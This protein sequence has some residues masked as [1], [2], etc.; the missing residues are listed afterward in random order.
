MQLSLVG[1]HDIGERVMTLDETTD[2]SGSAYIY[3]MDQLYRLM[4][5]VLI[6]ICL[7]TDS[8]QRIFFR[9]LLDG[10]AATLSQMRWSCLG[11]LRVR[12]VV[13]RAYDLRGVLLARGDVD[14]VGLD[15]MD[16]TPLWETIY[17][18]Q[19]GAGIFDESL[20]TITAIRSSR[21]RPISGRILPLY[22]VDV[23]LFTWMKTSRG[24][25]YR[26]NAKAGEIPGRETVGYTLEHIYEDLRLAEEALTRADVRRLIRRVISVR[27]Y[28]PCKH[29]GAALPYGVYELALAM[30][31]KH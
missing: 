17:R 10:S 29:S 8:T 19:Y 25:S 14:D 4:M 12:I 3:H 26:D 27:Q 7:T 30:R 18:F 2:K 16:L 13:R 28:R 1:N 22:V 11:V 31:P 20:Q 21:E 5:E 6:F 15:D 24:S 9:G 23:T